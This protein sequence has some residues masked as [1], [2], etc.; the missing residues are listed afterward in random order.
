VS[1]L[2][3]ISGCEDVARRGD[4]VFVHG[5][6]GDAFATWRHD[7]DESDSWPH[8]LGLKCPDVGVWSLGYAASPTLWARLLPVIGLGSRD[9]GYSMALPDRAL[10][11]LDLMVRRGIGERPLLFVCHSL[12]GLLAKQLL[13]KSSDSPDP[14]AR[15]VANRT[16]AVL[17]LATP[18]TG[19][20]L[21]SLANTFRA[22]FGST[23]SV[24]DL[25]EH[26][27]HLRDLYDW[28]RHHAPKLQIQTVTYFE[29]RGV[30][31]VLTI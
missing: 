6:G 26:D 21:A 13:R 2:H 9:S 16:R 3:K 23:V 7:R 18:H 5:L 17:F 24:E 4:V 11:A 25:R 15:Q 1:R 8:W 31:G 22:V 29:S 19:A 12:G 14:R 27:A 20:A 30:K 10:Q 28:Y